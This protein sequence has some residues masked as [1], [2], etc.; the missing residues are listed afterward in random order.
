VPRQ[1]VSS[2]QEHRVTLG[3]FERKE[4]AGFIKSQERDEDL[5]LVLSAVQAL[6]TPIAIV[7]VGYLGYLGLTHFS[8]MLDPLQDAAKA[9][10]AVSGLD[11]FA[12]GMDAGEDPSSL[13]P[14]Q[15]QALANANLNPLAR[16]L[17]GYGLYGGFLRRVFT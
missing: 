9:A 5:D 12:A 17:A 16:G 14:E 10:A 15:I 13:T 7:S 8:S 11:A 1:P 6:A 4:L 3:D 2:V